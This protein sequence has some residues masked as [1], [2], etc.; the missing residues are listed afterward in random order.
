M[1]QLT[2]AGMMQRGADEAQRA[3]SPGLELAPEIRRRVAA[4]RDLQVVAL[5][6]G[7]RRRLRED[8]RRRLAEALP[9]EPTGRR[10][11]SP[12][13]PSMSGALS[14]ERLG[15]VLPW[16]RGVRAQHRRQ[17][18][19]RRCR[20]DRSR[21]RRSSD[22]SRPGRAGQDHDESAPQ[23]VP[24][25]EGGHDRSARL[26]RPPLGDGGTAPARL[27]A[28][29][30]LD[31]GRTHRPGERDLV[32]TALRALPRGERKRRVLDAPTGWD[33]TTRRPAR[34]AP[35]PGGMVLVELARAWSTAPPCSC[36]TSRRSSS[37]GRPATATWRRVEEHE[38]ALVGV[39]LLTTHYMEA[40][41]LCRPGRRSYLED[42]RT[43]SDPAPRL[44][45][46][47]LSSQLNAR[48]C[49]PAF[50]RAS[51]RR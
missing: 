42:D 7:T 40:E 11:R 41:I 30:A 15:A 36:S 34:R 32:C 27:R 24:A 2:A 35:L 18:C 8:D 16:C 6:D 1:G 29:A 20:P 48:G 4:W 21:G 19:A 46:D 22:C 28:A 9:A 25:A 49:L 31:R 10:A 47:A 39:V 45:E 12:R 44:L 26:R 5:Q 33:S 38:R 37:A 17:P 51:L 13:K 50:H 14:A 23:H 43:G 3:R